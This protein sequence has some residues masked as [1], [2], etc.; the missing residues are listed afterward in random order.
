MPN[1]ENLLYKVLNHFAEGCLEVCHKML[2][3]EL[4]FLIQTQQLHEEIH[5]I[6][7]QYKHPYL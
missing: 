4:S 3:K 7:S 5:L 6:C 2:Q 1:I